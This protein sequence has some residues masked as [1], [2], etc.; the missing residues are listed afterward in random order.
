MGFALIFNFSLAAYHII[1]VIINDCFHQIRS[2]IADIVKAI[3][4]IVLSYSGKGTGQLMKPSVTVGKMSAGCR[5]FIENKDGFLHC[6]EIFL[7]EPLPKIMQYAVF[8]FVLQIFCY[9][10][11]TDKYR[12][13][14][15][16]CGVHHTVRDRSSIH[17]IN[18]IVL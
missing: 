17:F 14:T 7:F 13:F 3:Q 8:F 11:F 9:S 2:E 15:N 6:T 12:M 16:R 5:V 4:I 1:I 10:A 18:V